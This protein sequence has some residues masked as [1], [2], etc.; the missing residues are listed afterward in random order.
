MPSLSVFI[1]MLLMIPLV[2]AVATALFPLLL[3]LFRKWSQEEFDQAS[4]APGWALVVISALGFVVSIFAFQFSLTGD[5]IPAYIAQPV[6][7]EKL[8][9]LTDPFTVF[10]TMVL[11][12]AVVTVAW[13]V[14]ARR[15]FLS[16]GTIPAVLSALIIFCAVAQI[17][18]A[19]FQIS[20]TIFIISSLLMIIVFL[21]T[22]PPGDNWRKWIPV[23]LLIIAVF[24]GIIGYAGL[25]QLSRGVDV[26]SW[27]QMQI[28]AAP[29]RVATAIIFV[30][31]AWVFQIIVFIRLAWGKGASNVLTP[32]PA[33]VA[34][35]GGGILA[36]TRM[37]T[38][39]CLQQNMQIR[40]GITSITAHSLGIWSGMLIIIGIIIATV[41]LIRIKKG[42]DLFEPKGWPIG[43]IVAGMFLSCLQ[44]VLISQA[45][46]SAVI[47]SVSFL[48]IGCTVIAA[49]FAIIPAVRLSDS[50]VRINVFI[51]SGIALL[52]SQ[53]SGTG[54][55]WILSLWS[56]ISSVIPG[57]L[58]TFLAV[59]SLIICAIYIWK[60]YENVVGIE[61][62]GTRWG[63]WSML[64]S[65]VTTIIIAASLWTNPV[66][67]D[68]LR[69]A[70]LQTQ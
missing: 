56:S 12:L 2:G 7:A 58:I 60:K 5:G 53:L 19:S 33:I 28:F 41:M 49:G 26:R 23:L 37:L 21:I 47:G 22:D 69:K 9:F 25:I 15:A 14:A 67:I 11:F 6:A 54:N 40:E 48:L 64:I 20:L 36:F 24:A 44:S 18:S 65:V 32:L 10:A 38:A 68:A 29:S 16:V 45:S 13:P 50:V 17:N 63:V 43:F 30:A 61:E 57:W 4:R 35:A 39:I 27:W 34:L 66:I 1:L 52:L 70:L 3:P 62:P 55:W 51:L 8:L 59:Y 42:Q 31:I 46:L